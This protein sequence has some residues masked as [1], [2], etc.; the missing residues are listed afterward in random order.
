M[1]KFARPA[2]LSPLDADK[3]MMLLG[4]NGIVLNFNNGRCVPN[5][6]ELRLFRC[7]AIPLPPDLKAVVGR[8]FWNDVSQLIDL[9]RKFCMAGGTDVL[10]LSDMLEDEP[11]SGS[12]PDETEASRS[13]AAVPLRSVSYSS[14]L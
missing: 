11:G 10:D 5:T 1:H 14:R 8:D 2:S 12:E 4:D 3:E 7:C 9:I 6:A 13:C